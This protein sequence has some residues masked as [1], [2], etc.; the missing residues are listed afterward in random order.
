MGKQFADKAA[1]KSKLW[2]EIAQNLIEKGYRLGEN[3]GEKCRQKFSNLHI[4]YTKYI[5]NQKATGSEKMETPP[6]YDEMQ[7]ILGNT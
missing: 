4:N 1:R 5:L 3:A 2:T 7:E 6:Y